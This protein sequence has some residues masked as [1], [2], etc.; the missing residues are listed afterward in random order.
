ML[1]ISESNS[2]LPC[3]LIKWDNDFESWEGWPESETEIHRCISIC[4]DTHT[5][6]AVYV[7]HT[8]A[9]LVSKKKICIYIRGIEEQ[10]W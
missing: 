8:I 10:I 3:D 6:N 9:R 2:A 5:Q 1:S 4:A 7:I